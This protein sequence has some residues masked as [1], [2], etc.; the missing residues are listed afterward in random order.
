LKLNLK[1]SKNHKKKHLRKDKQKL[2]DYL[3][4]NTKNENIALLDETKK[5]LYHAEITTEQIT[6]KIENLYKNK[7]NIFFSKLADNTIIK[8]FKWNINKTTL[9]TPYNTISVSDTKQFIKYFINKN[10]PVIENP[11]YKIFNFQH[12]DKDKY[13]NFND[14]L[15]YLPSLAIMN[16]EE[17]ENLAI[18][19]NN[20][21]D[22]NY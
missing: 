16:E 19:I 12:N 21:S 11:T 15:V 3:E 14:S 18:L 4:E 20:Y 10:I 9:L 2:K 17:I 22:N 6:E 8:M 1:R 7:S 5:S 13:K